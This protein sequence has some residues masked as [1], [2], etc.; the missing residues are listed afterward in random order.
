MALGNTSVTR[1]SFEMDKLFFFNPK[2]ETREDAVFITGLARSGTTILLRV[3]YETGLFRSLTY[4]DMPFV[5]MPNL[6]KRIHRASA[7][8]QPKE[9]AHGDRILVNNHSPENFESVFW[10]TLTGE[11]FIHNDY[12]E[13]YTVSP[14]LILQ[15][16]AFIQLVLNSADN[17]LQQRYLSKNNNNILR[18]SSLSEAFPKAVFLLTFRD[19]L[20]HA[21]SLLQ[22]HLRFSKMQQEDPFTLQYMNWMGHFEFGLGHKPF[23][24]EG[25][26]ELEELKQYQTSSIN[27]W[28]LV[29]KNYYSYLL[30]HIP[31]NGILLQYEAICNDTRRVWD[32]LTPLLGTNIS[33]ADNYFVAATTKHPEGAN[34]ALL[35]DCLRVYEQLLEKKL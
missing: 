27:Y 24:L 29:W 11:Q 20:Q 32:H 26:A 30:N 2:K 28:L 14:E 3:L 5:L 9:R 4:A 23:V 17:P 8:T 13:K 16:K 6:W 25:L 1:V 33:P 7:V 34:E 35:S 22:Q 19:P 21:A 31:A 18:L 15:F 12:L 10:K